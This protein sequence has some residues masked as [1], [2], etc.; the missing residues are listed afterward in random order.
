MSV[1]V[2]AAKRRAAASV[3]LPLPAATSTHGFAGTQ[4]DSF[5]EQLADD[6]KGR[7]NDGKIPRRPHRLLTRIE[8][9]RRVDACT[10]HDCCPFTPYRYDLPHPPD[11]RARSA[12]D[13]EVTTRAILL[14]A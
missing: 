1:D 12:R 11:A 4:I 2:T 5:A 3:A 8:R 7:S 6:L 14:D 10:G 13:D 9:H